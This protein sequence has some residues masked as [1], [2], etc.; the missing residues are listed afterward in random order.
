MQQCIQH[1]TIHLSTYISNYPYHYGTTHS[2]ILIII[3]PSTYSFNKIYGWLYHESNCYLLFIKI[4]I[5]LP[6]QLFMY[7]NHHQIIHLS[8]LGFIRSINH[9]VSH[10]F[11]HS[12]I[13]QLSKHSF[14]QVFNEWAILPSSLVLNTMERLVIPSSVLLLS[15]VLSH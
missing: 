13:I 1:P 11:K 4:P 15:L 10:P 3:L 6:I 14:V 12:V 5:H 9:I 7:P 2:T 8:I